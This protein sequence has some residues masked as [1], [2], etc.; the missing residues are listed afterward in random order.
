MISLIYLKVNFVKFTGNKDKDTWS[1][2]KN[3]TQI[4]LRKG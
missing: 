2:N 1:Q 4:K 3:G